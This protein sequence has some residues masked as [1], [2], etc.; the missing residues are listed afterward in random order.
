MRGILE[1]LRISLAAVIL[2]ACLLLLG[3]VSGFTSLAHADAVATPPSPYSLEADVSMRH[4]RVDVAFSGARLVIFGSVNSGTVQADPRNLDVVAVIEGARTG[5]TV[6]RKSRVFGLWLNTAS[7]E[8]NDAPKYY[9]V[10]STRPISE[11]APKSV[12]A[13]LGVGLDDVPITATARPKDGAKEGPGDKTL[14]EF[15]T[16]AIGLGAREKHYVRYDRAISFVGSSLFRGEIDLPANVPVG[17]LDVRV[18]L[19]GGR[20]LLAR[21]DSHLQLEREGFEHFIYAF[22]HQNPFIYGVATVLM[23]AGIGL[24]ASIIAGRRMR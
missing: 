13:D 24:F 16:A 21:H 8:F 19:F 17:D 3:A 14:D 20:V 15:R 10:A 6:R 1:R 11:I 23:A 18:Y 2:S 4:I 12:L 5:L 22:A 7:T 9:A